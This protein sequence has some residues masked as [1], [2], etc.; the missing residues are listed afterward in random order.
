MHEGHHMTI[1]STN[2]HNVSVI[3]ACNIVGYKP[4]RT[5]VIGVFAGGVGIGVTSVLADKF[6][7]LI[8]SGVLAGSVEK[9]VLQKVRQPRQLQRVCH[10]ADFDLQSNVVKRG[11]HRGFHHLV[12]ST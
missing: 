8:L 7:V 1:C 11:F 5:V 9:H 3:A 6:A 10:A 2:I 12:H 4:K